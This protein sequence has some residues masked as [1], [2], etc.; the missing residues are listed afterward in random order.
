MAGAD[1]NVF[2][3]STGRDLW[4]YRQA[5]LKV[6]DELDGYRCIHMEAFDARDAGAEEFCRSQ[7]RASDLLV[8]IVGHIH[9][10][11]P[12]GSE[13]SFTEIEYDQAKEDHIPRLMFVAPADFPVPASLFEPDGKRARQRAFR[14]RVEVDR[15]RA[16]FRNPD[17]LRAEIAV[18][19]RN[20]EQRQV[21]AAPSGRIDFARLFE[22]HT[23]FVGRAW[24][25]SALDNFIKE[26]KGGY[27]IV[28]GKPGI[29]K[30]SFA[31][32]LVRNRQYL[33]HFNS[34]KFSVFE[35]KQFIKN[36]SAQIHGRYSPDYRKPSEDDFHGSAYLTELLF[37]TAKTI[38]GEQPIVVV[39]DALDE[40]ESPA[41][42]GTNPLSLPGALP[43]NVVFLLTRRDDTK[44][45]LLNASNPKQVQP[46][47]QSSKD[48]LADV[49]DFLD[50]ALKQPLVQAFRSRQPGL[51]DAALNR[52]LLERSEGNFMYLV[53]VVQGI[54]SGEY[55]LTG[56]RSLPQGLLEYY[57]RHWQRI[58]QRNVEQWAGLF[59]PIIGALAVAREPLSAAAISVFVGHKLQKVSNRFEI[60]AA[61]YELGEFL[62]ISTVDGDRGYSLYHTSFREFLEKNV[63][64]REF[65]DES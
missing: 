5:A 56:F 28:E 11:S 23:G 44:G 27:F 21:R 6:F 43:S 13:R 10:A 18:S 2:L 7:V 63:E 4:E 65:M 64:V 8:G 29:G 24:L 17:E 55:D 14:D 39:V 20:W 22:E 16:S 42:V 19:I 35:T 34:L 40:A 33:H 49:H 45:F 59:L 38:P 37:S 51:D 46:M 61:L 52:L 32:D 36:L 53:H 57:G 58:R 1:R 3:S 62:E 15:I 30:T 26:G 54:Q 48:N 31:V 12:I 47:L 50:I 9:G 41:R 60:T 25:R